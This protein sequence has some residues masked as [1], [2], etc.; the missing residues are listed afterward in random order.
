MLYRVPPV[1]MLRMFAS[2][3]RTDRYEQYI[4]ASK[5]TRMSIAADTTTAAHLSGLASRNPANH[6]AAQSPSQRNTGVKITNR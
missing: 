3:S 6:S 1:W 5:K 4:G 2:N